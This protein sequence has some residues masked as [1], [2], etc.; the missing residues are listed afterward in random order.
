[1]AVFLRCM[2]NAS[3]PYLLVSPEAMNTASSAAHEVN[4]MSSG[5]LLCP[6][7]TDVNS[8]MMLSR[9]STAQPRLLLVHQ[10]YIVRIPRISWSRNI[11]T[12]GTSLSRPPKRRCCCAITLYCDYLRFDLDADG[13]CS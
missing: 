3:W 9:L 8:T 6:S 2:L 5:S 7:N 4:F 11:P 12:A 1:M 10:V 13:K